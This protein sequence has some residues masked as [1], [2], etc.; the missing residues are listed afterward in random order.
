ML[1]NSFQDASS[2]EDAFCHLRNFQLQGTLCDV[3]IRCCQDETVEFLA[4]RVILAAKSHYFYTMFT[5][6]L[7][8][9]TEEV[10][11]LKGITSTAFGALLKYAYSGNVDINSEN[12]EEILA[13][14]HML[15]FENVQDACFEFLRNNIDCVNCIAISHLAE[16]YNCKKAQMDADEFS[17]QNFRDVTKTREFLEMDVDYVARLVSSDELNVTNESEIY[18]AIMNWAK[19]KEASRAQFLWQLL[20]YLRIPL[21]SRKFLIDVLAKEELI[22][23][24]RECR[25]FLLDALDYHL[26][27]ERRDQFHTEKTGPRDKVTRKIFV[28]GGESKLKFT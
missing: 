24:D 4:H 3:T 13:A 12:I 1:A 20:S 21:L 8:E 22:I 14:A 6:G 5:T 17:R 9:K 7:M 25:G 23:G 19:Y 2:C 10:I 28:I 11:T 26:L 18:T 16:K 27:P 15:Q